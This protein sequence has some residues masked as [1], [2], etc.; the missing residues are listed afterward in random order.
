M[1]DFEESMD[2]GRDAEKR[3]AAT[4][5]NPV[6]ATKEE[7][8]NDHW[9]VMDSMGYRYDVKAMKKYRRSDNE[10]TDRIHWVELRNVNGKMGWLY[11]KAYYIAFETRSWWI[12]VKREDLVKF[13]EGAIWGQEAKIER[14]KP[15]ELYQR[16]DRQDLM[17]VI[18]T[19]DLLAIAE[20]VDSKD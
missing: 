1:R 18:P 7:D 2:I 5:T 12:V 6:F 16:P 9:D 11:G 17:T 10:E 19:V 3:F 13:I 14:P 20:R 4:L 15:Y 8:I